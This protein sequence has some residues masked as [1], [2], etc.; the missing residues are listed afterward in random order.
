M[1]CVR[2]R[3]VV[4]S[5][6]LLLCVGSHAVRAQ[7]ALF[8]LQGLVTDQQGAV[9]PGATVTAHNLAT[10]LSRPAVTDREGRYLIPALPPAGTYEIRVE[11][12]GFATEIRTNQVF[13]A[14]IS[15]TQNFV[16]K[17]SSVSETVTVTAQ[18]AIVDTTSA[19][20]S[21]T[22]TQQA[23]EALPVKTHNYFNLITLNS[24]MYIP[25][26]TDNIYSNAGEVWTVGT[27]VDG[28]DNF[29]RQLTLQAGPQQGSGGFAYE[30]VKEVQIIT[31]QYSAEFG[32]HSG[33][34]ISAI[35]KSGTNSF[36]GSAFLG[37][38]P[39]SLDAK[40][41]L[42]KVATPYSQQQFGATLGGPIKQDR[43]FFF[44]NYQQRRERS[45]VVVTSPA[46]PGLVVPTPADEYI[47]HGRVDIRFSDSKLLA[48]RANSDDWH[49]TYETGGLSL[50]GT[51]FDWKNY[52]H[53]AHVMYNTV[54]SDKK[55][56]ELR[57]QFIRYYDLRSAIGKG[58][59]LAYAGYATEGNNATS[60]Q[61]YGI[62]EDAYD[63]SDT[64]TLLS[65]PH[66]F[67][68]GG[69]YNYNRGAELNVTN[70]DGVYRF[71]GAPSVTPTPYL[72]L[73]G[74]ELTPGVGQMK[75]KVHAFIGY[76]Q[77]DWHAARH[78]TLNLGLRYMV[79]LIRDTLG[80]NAPADKRNFDP[81]IGMSWDV[82]G[83]QKWVVRAGAG[84]FTQQQL[85]YTF[86]RGGLFGPQGVVSLS[87]SPTSPGFPVFPNVLPAFPAGAVLPARNVEFMSNDLR[88]EYAWQGTAGVQH[89]LGPQTV[90]AID[91]AYVWAMKH[92][93]LDMN[94]PAPNPPGNIRSIAQADLTRP[95]LPVPGGFRNMAYLTNQGRVWYHGTHV[96]IQ[97]RM[98]QFTFMANYTYATST[99]MLNHWSVPPDST[100]PL[101]DKGPSTGD[102]RHNF[103]SSA[104]WS[105]PFKNVVFKG[106]DLSAIIQM[107]SG[108]PYNITYG[109][110]RNGTGQGDARPGGRMTGRQDSYSDVDFSV[111]RVIP[112]TAR[113]RFELR[114]M[115]FNLLNTMNYTSY[116]GTLSSLSFGKPTSGMPGRQF[117]LE[118]TFRF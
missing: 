4:G 61:G 76:V 84:R 72:F 24:S 114:A 12:T 104:T 86:I 8:D 25:P 22:I 64:F 94:A 45:N 108:L 111:T 91:Y 98:R 74:F 118:M 81:R 7:K 14:G 5:L 66:N 20:V 109:D 9:L 79:E 112:V 27:Y 102:I 67:K 43:V 90:V 95:I 17:L 80:Y 31:N 29:S 89:E 36:T 32:G 83:N 55:L 68:F 87:L 99:D 54:L 116:V 39:G 28:I 48:I 77:D 26:G 59:Q 85:T 37:V 63:I 105:A 16:L 52:S 2:C 34:T 11:L 75:P 106:W 30:T 57:G 96:S 107:R 70:D 101:L 13:T 62:P 40:P 19:R 38:R 23:M 88:N 18:T 35:T 46:A 73:Q 82:A 10:G 56:N 110:D 113:T 100:N 50:P 21:S 6:I 93:Y 15:A 49:K 47:T 42:A 53:V 58:P 103:V 1:S 92:G 69:E 33:A 71:S 65:G 60:A 117:Q 51:G 44:A 41:P 97:H 78:L 3:T 115:S